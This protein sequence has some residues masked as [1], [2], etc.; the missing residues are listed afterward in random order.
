LFLIGAGAFNWAI[1][2]RFAV[3]IWND[4]R[5]WSGAVGHSSPTAFLTVHAVLIA[6]AVAIGT[7]VGVLGVRGLRSAPKPAP[8]GRFI[9]SGRSEHP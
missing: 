5:A 8:N 2:P 9:R 3:A 4:R 6:A 1:W 7:A